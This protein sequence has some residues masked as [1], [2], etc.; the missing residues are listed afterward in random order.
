MISNRFFSSA[1]CNYIHVVLQHIDVFLGYEP[2]IAT[3]AA[4]V[5]PILSYTNPS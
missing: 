5:I 3:Y 1:L 2:T 4:E